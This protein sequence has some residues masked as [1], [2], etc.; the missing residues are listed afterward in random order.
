MNTTHISAP[1]HPISPSPFRP[2]VNVTSPGAAPQPATSIEYIFTGRY[3]VTLTP[4]RLGE[5]T[6]RI[7]LDGKPLARAVIVIAGCPFELQ[8]PLDDGTCG[9][10][11]GTQLI[12][13][14]GC[15]PCNPGFYSPSI[16]SEG[17]LPCED[18]HTT[19]AA[20]ADAASAC[21]CVDGYYRDT[22]SANAPCRACPEGAACASHN[23]GNV[24]QQPRDGNTTQQ[25]DNLTL[26]TLVLAR[27]NWRLS[28]LTNDIR[29]CG[30]NVT[31]AWCLGGPEPGNGS[32]ANGTKGPLC[33]VCAL[34]WHYPRESGASI[35]CLEC[36]ARG[37]AAV[38]YAAALDLVVVLAIVLL[39]VFLLRRR[40]QPSCSCSWGNNKRDGGGGEGGGDSGNEGGNGGNSC[41]GGAAGTARTEHVSRFASIKQ[42][43]EHVDLVGKVKLLIS[44]FQIVLALPNVNHADVSPSPPSPPMCWKPLSRSSHH[45]LRRCLMSTSQRSTI[46]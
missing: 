41:A 27:G 28:R 43:S 37:A 40:S 18:V 2:A 42:V 29:S 32:C 3:R 19:S 45:L 38:V 16:G 23:Q 8:S 4:T 6:A 39:T 13:G 36:S 5:Y 26:S 24:T 15:S 20:G 44:Y 33:R 10:Q 35:G 9:C 14:G 31:S 7:A 17:C 21:V 11:P 30:G 34:P 46:T 1:K 12:A 25:L 22:G